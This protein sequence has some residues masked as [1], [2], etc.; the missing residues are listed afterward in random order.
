MSDE[1]MQIIEKDSQTS[2]NVAIE[3]KFFI[4]FLYYLIN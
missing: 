4:I 2:N 3:I 1:K